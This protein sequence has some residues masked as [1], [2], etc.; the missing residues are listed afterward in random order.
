MIRLTTRH[1]GLRFMAMERQMITFPKT[2]IGNAPFDPW[3]DVAGMA[4]RAFE[5]DMQRVFLQRGMWP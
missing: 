5:R 3:L 1:K 4:S 2:W